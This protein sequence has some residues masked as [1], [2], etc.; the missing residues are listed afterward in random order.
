ME[1]DIRAAI[2][3]VWRMESAKIVAVLTRMVRDIGTAED[4]AQDVLVTALEKW[5]RTGM[6][7]NPGAWLMAVAKRRAIDGFRRRRRTERVEWELGREAEL[8]TEVA[9][10][11]P[12]PPIK[13]E[14]EDD[15]LRLIF[16]VSHPIL[17]TEGRVALTL[18]TLAGLT[19]E[20]IARAFL[21]SEATVAQRIVRAKRTLREA[22]VP[23]EVPSG[24][25]LVQRV[26]SVLEVIYLVFN[27]G[28]TATAGE[29]W[30][31][32]ELCDDAL[33]MGRVLAAL[34]PTESEVH[35][36]VALMELQSSRFGARLGPEGE[37]I[38]LLQQDRT[39]W[40]RLLIRRGLAALS[41]AQ[42][43]G[44]TLGPYALQ[45][46]IAA[47]HAV[48]VRAE[49]TDWMRISALYDAL[50][51]LLPT[52]IVALNRAVSYAM[53]YGTEAG[54]ALV[55]EL[56]EEPS[57]QAYHLLPGVRGDFLAK[58]GR[59]SEAETEFLRAASLTKN[60][61]ERKLLLERATSCTEA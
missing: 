41:L 24:P 43:L 5:P 38:L 59:C 11:N 55:D 40:D 48:A 37:P 15:L 27:E 46:S 30:V 52:P 47:C 42:G 34:A 28:Y 18:R 57:L 7:E 51:Q 17:P 58:L 25:E 10:Y 29:D 50:S 3:A 35:G 49:E 39:R 45:A 16:T 1:A 31:R 56:T 23:F 21:V 44:G 22:R 53:A 4:L 19:T 60:S 9:R 14:I 12:D 61:R 36:L 20:E 26:S 8:Q 6:P 54:L 32:P 2:E 33:R 13:E